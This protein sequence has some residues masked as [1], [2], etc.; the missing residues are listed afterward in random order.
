MLKFKNMEGLKLEAP[1]EFDSSQTNQSNA[2]P[3]YYAQIHV[4]L[5]SQ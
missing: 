2:D 4:T 3:L 5:F 1:K